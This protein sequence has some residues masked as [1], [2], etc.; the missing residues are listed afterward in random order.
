MRPDADT[1]SI[2]EYLAHIDE[3]T[4]IH[5]AGAMLIAESPGTDLGRF[6]DASMS[7]EVPHLDALAVLADL[8]RHGATYGAYLR[9]LDDAPW[10]GTMTVGGDVI[11]LEWLV[12]HTCHDLMHH[13]TDLAR[14][15]HRLG[16]VVAPMS[17][18]VASI[19]ASDGGVPKPSIPIADVDLGGVVGDRQAAREHHGR[20]W[21]ALCVWSAEVV[22]GF[23]AEGHP[24]A[25]GAAGE[26]LSLA[27][28]DWA[29]LR[30]GLLMQ[31][32]DV[33]ARLS[34][35]AVPCTKNSRWFSDGD[36][37]R[38][39]HDRSPGRSRWYASVLTPGRIR[40]GDE[41]EIRSS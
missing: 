17:G 31:I 33:T 2:V 23:A 22:A 11:S 26:N 15:R 4:A 30:A 7:S 20:P 12:R 41:V 35:P 14:I 9:S 38:L 36:H 37:Q 18:T 39:G 40:S 8:D 24:I 13:L 5:N 10:A 3:V 1:W 19:H 34:A 21:Q 16:D 29:A 28:L 27:G 25:P 32:G 6:P